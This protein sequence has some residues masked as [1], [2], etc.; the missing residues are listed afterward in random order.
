MRR[1][2]TTFLL[3]LPLAA[4]IALPAAADVRTKEKTFVK[5]EGVLGGALR[6]FGGKAAREGIVSTTVVK[7]DRKAMIGESSSQVVDLGEEKIYDLDMKKKEYKV[8]TFAEL[9]RRMEEERA[10]AE[11]EAQKEAGREEKPEKAEKTEPQKEYEVDFD[12]KETGQKKQLA[13]YDTRE[14]IMTVTLREKG[15]PLEENGGFVMTSTSWMGPRIAALKEL[16][17]FELRYWK[18]LYGA[19]ATALSAEQMAAVM[20]LYPALKQANERLSKEGKKLEGTPLSTTTVFEVVK[21]KAMM[22]QS[23]ESSGGG[24]LGGMLA[25]RMKKDD[26][27][28]RATVFTTVHEFQE[29]GTSVAASDLELPAGFKEKK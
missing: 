26:P 23:K 28:Q 29:V 4:A 10:R 3:A 17:D 14:V 9:R 15:K 27:K 19:E 8:T 1:S 20:A 22:E 5:L 13:G 18:Q 7:G 21:S 6:L 16:T 24:G 25:R 2:S 11:K 12:V